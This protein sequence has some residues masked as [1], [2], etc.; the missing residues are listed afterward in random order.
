MWT[1]LPI[2][3]LELLDFSTIPVQ[4]GKDLSTWIPEG[5]DVTPGYCGNGPLQLSGYN[6]QHSLYTTCVYVIEG[7]IL[8]RFN[9]QLGGQWDNL[10]CESFY[11]CH[12][13]EFFAPG[14][15]YVH[16]PFCDVSTETLNNLGTYGSL[17][18]PFRGE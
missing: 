2:G 4:P 6:V 14:R 3:S 1:Q 10:L 15:R 8:F 11:I 12:D 13:L 5:D 17:P 9:T 7:R 16:P 18:P